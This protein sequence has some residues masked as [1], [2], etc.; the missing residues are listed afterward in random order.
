MKLLTEASF[1][2]TCVYGSAFL[3]LNKNYFLCSKLRTEEDVSPDFIENCKVA[4]NMALTDMCDKFPDLS[5]GSLQ[6]LG[7]CIHNRFIVE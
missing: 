5:Q 7:L 1:Q 4:I 2:M 6:F 3:F